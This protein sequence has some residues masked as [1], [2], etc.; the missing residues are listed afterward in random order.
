[1]IALVMVYSQGLQ[2]QNARLSILRPSGSVTH[3]WVYM[4][5]GE[6][7]TQLGLQNKQYP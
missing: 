5:S 2:A 3:Q 4:P 6:I 7:V 1:M